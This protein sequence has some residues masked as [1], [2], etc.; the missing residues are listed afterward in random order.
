MKI[1]IVDDQET[2]VEVVRRVVEDACA[3][4]V[5]EIRIASTVTETAQL[6][7]EISFDLLIL[8]VRLPI[9]RGESPQ[10]NGAVTLLDQIQARNDYHV[11]E[12]I[13]GLTA[14]EETDKETVLAFS[15]FG[16]NLL[17]YEEAANKWQRVIRR[18]IEHILNSARTASNEGFGTDL[19]IVTALDH[20]E[21]TAIKKLRGPW[22]RYEVKSDETVYHR[23]NWNSG[24]RAIEVTCASAIEMGMPAAC[25]LATKMCIQFRPRY[26]AMTGI[27]AGVGMNFG[28]LVV[29][30]R[31]WDYGS[32]KNYGIASGKDGSVILTRFDPAPTAISISPGL[33]EKL[34][35]LRQNRNVLKAIEVG[36][37]HGRPSTPLNVKAGSLA[38]GAAVLENQPLIE[39]IRGQ[40]RKVYGIDMETYGV[41]LAARVAPEPKPSCFVIKGVSDKG[42]IKKNDKWQ[43]YAAY[44]SA[45]YMYAFVTQE[46]FADEAT[47]S[48]VE[49][50]ARSSQ[51]L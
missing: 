27:C 8:D 5:C 14:Y 50:Q 3:G 40:D 21:L 49:T 29:A 15:E 30:E 23:A 46:L 11:P 25:A 9:R 18:R 7:T 26:L 28:D 17:R 41:F 36:W 12:H 16:W 22:S 34:K 19:C 35:Q 44:A 33:S 2:K 1:L 10:E 43:E 47:C 13:I 39:M 32:G 24:G 45:E 37:E 4:A 38:S 20:P 51:T 6:L 42:D 48:V 31:S